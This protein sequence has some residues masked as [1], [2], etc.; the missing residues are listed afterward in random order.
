MIGAECVLEARMRRAG[1]HEVCEPKL[2]DVSKPLERRS[3][4]KGQ[5]G[6]FHADVV[7]EG[8]AERGHW[9]EGWRMKGES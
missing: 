5:V 3:V 4:E 9:D 1:I 8:V 6:P 2:S 7:P